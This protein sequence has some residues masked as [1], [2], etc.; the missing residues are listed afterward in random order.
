M[1]PT[2][3][4]CWTGP[5][6]S[7]CS[8]LLR[9]KSS[10]VIEVR[11][12]ALL[13]CQ[14]YEALPDVEL[15]AVP[16]SWPPRLDD[17]TKETLTYELSTAP[18]TSISLITRFTCKVD[19]DNLV[20]KA[21]PSDL[22]AVLHAIKS[23]LE[24]LSTSKSLS[25]VDWN[26]VRSLEFREA[27]NGRDERLRRLVAMG[28]DR[29]GD[30]EAMVRCLSLTLVACWMTS[31]Q[32]LAVHAQRMLGDKIAKCAL[33]FFGQRHSQAGAQSTTGHF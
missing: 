20:S 12:S 22:E 30:F 1:P 9:Q 33:G 7:M 27:L 32:Y 10:P 6:N 13:A 25:E 11:S 4:G 14:W 3:L 5:N 24:E 28:L 15:D 18:L 2:T 31:K 26:K 29:D 17:I 8:L 21:R 16:P 19:G 23:T